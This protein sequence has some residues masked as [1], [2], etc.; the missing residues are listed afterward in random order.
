MEYYMVDV[1]DITCDMPNNYPTESVEQLAQSIVE[2]GLL[3]PLILKQIGLQ[4]YG[5]ISGEFEYY[6]ALRAKEVNPRKCEMV[7][8]FVIK[9]AEVGAINQQI[10]ILN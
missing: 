8:A 5:L 10:A 7:N 3:R 6:A 1:K 4:S 2:I 9:Q